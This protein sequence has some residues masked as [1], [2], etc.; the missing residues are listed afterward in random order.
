MRVLRAED[1][2]KMAR[3]VVDSYLHQ[4]VPLDSGLAKVATDEGLNPDQIQNLV[5]LANSIAHLTLF[6]GKEDGD[7]I[8]EFNPADPDVVLKKVYKDGVPECGEE[9]SVPEASPID[10]ATDFFGDFPDMSKK[11]RELTGKPDDSPVSTEA[12]DNATP[13][14]KSMVIIKIRKVAEELKDREL[15]SAMEYKE[16]LDKLAAEFAKL[17]G[18]NYADFEKDALAVRGDLALPVLCDVRSCLRMPPIQTA[19]LEKTARVVDAE[20]SLLESLD[21]LIKLSTRHQ[22]S[23]AAYDYLKSKVGGIL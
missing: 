16:E 18:P 14:R 9:D 6:D 2:E 12:T 20:T 23:R 5:Q 1:F 15:A 17:Y 21:T 22:E 11:I 7:K 8:V 10:S 3:E 19:V 13:A 4:S